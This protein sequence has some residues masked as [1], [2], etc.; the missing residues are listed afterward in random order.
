M[1]PGAHSNDDT[2]TADASSVN[3]SGTGHQAT[4]TPN[5]EGEQ[6]VSNT[7]NTNTSG[8]RHRAGDTASKT[9]NTTA[10][11]R[12]RADDTASGSKGGTSSASSSKADSKEK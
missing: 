3:T 10:P 1:T 8:G 6:D 11:G 5:T 4:S 7:T 2:T 9:T 12:H